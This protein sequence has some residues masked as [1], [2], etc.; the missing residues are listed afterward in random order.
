MSDEFDDCD[1]Q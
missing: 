1:E